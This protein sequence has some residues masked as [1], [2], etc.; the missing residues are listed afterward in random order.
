MNIGC[1]ILVFLTNLSAKILS[2]DYQS[3]SSR[4]GRNI[5]SNSPTLKEKLINSTESLIFV[6]SKVINP[7]FKKYIVPTPSIRL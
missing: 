2:V 6:A 4:F 5:V 3:L 7:I 1:F